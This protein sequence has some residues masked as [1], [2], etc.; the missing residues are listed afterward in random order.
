MSWQCT[1]PLI[2]KS[3]ARPLPQSSAEPLGRPTSGVGC[4]LIPR[5]AGPERDPR[6][7]LIGRLASQGREYKAPRNDF[8]ACWKRTKIM[9]A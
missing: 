5:R 3:A 7:C 4:S 1:D 2:H 9:G 6:C 8:W